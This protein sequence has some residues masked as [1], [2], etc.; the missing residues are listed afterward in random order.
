LLAR[1][2][3]HTT[4]IIFHSLDVEFGL[5]RLFEE[6]GYGFIGVFTVSNSLIV[7][8]HMDIN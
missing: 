2:T 3:T 6:T 1:N 4:S 7:I 5:R 8:S